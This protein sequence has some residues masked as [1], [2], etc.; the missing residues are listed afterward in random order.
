MATS[1]EKHKKETV[2]KKT[3]L[4]DSEM[5]DSH[6]DTEDSEEGEEIDLNIA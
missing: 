3:C 1:K 4:I 5:S 6:N 2:T